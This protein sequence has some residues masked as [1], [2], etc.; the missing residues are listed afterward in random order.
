M[1]E[2]EKMMK[3]LQMYHFAAVDASLFLDTHPNDK[4]ALSYF[5]KV[6]KL[7]DDAREAYEKKYGPVT[8]G[9]TSGRTSWEWAT[10][11]WPW[12]VDA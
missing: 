10:K 12:E 9:S 8:I 5:N 4:E 6:K 2:R 11:P 1:T 7:A 3:Q